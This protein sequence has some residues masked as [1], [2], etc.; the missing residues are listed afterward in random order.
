[1]DLKTV[2]MINFK[3]PASKNKSDNILLWMDIF[4]G[5]MVT[6]K[7]KP[8]LITDLEKTVFQMNSLGL[9]LSCDISLVSYNL[10]SFSIID[11]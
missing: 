3:Q 4:T 11:S 6:I 5:H 9:Y 8:K 2:P 10:D 1:M 7:N